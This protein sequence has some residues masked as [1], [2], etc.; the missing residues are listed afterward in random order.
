MDDRRRPP[1]HP[2]PIPLPSLPNPP[3]PKSLTTAAGVAIRA[4]IKPLDPTQH[5]VKPLISIF[6][7]C[8]SN[9]SSPSESGLITKI[10]PAQCRRCFGFEFVSPK[11]GSPMLN[12]FIQCGH[13]AAS[14]RYD[15]CLHGKICMHL[16]SVYYYSNVFGLKDQVC[17]FVEIKPKC[18]FLP[19]P[20]YISVG[21]VVKKRIAHFRMHQS[22]KLHEREVS[23]IS[24]Y[25]LLDMFT[26]SKDRVHKAIK[27]LFVTPQNNF[28]VFLNGSVIYGGLGGGGDSISHMIGK[29]DVLKSMIRTDDGLRTMN[30]LHLGSVRFAFY[31]SF[32]FVFQSLPYFFLQT[33]SLLLKLLVRCVEIWVKTKCRTD[34]CICIHCLWMKASKLNYLIAAPAKD[35][36]MMI[37]F[38]P[39]KE[40][41]TESS[42]SSVFLKSTNQI[43][44]YKVV[45]C[46]AH[47]TNGEHQVDNSVSIEAYRTAYSDQSN[48]A[49]DVYHARD[50][51]G[52]IFV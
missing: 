8:E 33:K 22:L 43:F 21:N 6:P 26:G 48:T 39:R 32:S 46:N 37:C 31:F 16:T 34:S 29:E 45:S 18:R 17:I 41:D 19:F 30:F 13:A 14:K 4:L 24:E 42:Y 35:L 10:E 36:S 7:V 2:P 12:S 28:C 40:K 20:R 3:P 9:D 47:I 25:D 50:P 51:G 44:D 5:L 15:W 27:A 52:N 1:R 11:L 38:Q 49:E 23:E